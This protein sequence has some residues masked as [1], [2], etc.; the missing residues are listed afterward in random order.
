MKL[1]KK[2]PRL[3]KKEA[4]VVQAAINFKPQTLKKK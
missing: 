1:Q 3:R 2:I 4:P